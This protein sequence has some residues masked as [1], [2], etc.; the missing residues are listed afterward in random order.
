MK[1][2][3]DPIFTVLPL[4]IIAIFVAIPVSGVY[5]AV[6]L[7]KTINQ[8]CNTNYSLMEVALNGDK[9]IELCKVKNQTLTLK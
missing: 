9:L 8:E 1:H 2:P 6:T 5:Q 4:L 7:Q 3:L